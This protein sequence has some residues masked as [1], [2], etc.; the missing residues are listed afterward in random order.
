V[1][2]ATKG[3]IAKLDAWFPK[4]FV[5]DALGMVYPQYWI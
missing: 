3:Y 4:Q 5:L 2:E 1:L